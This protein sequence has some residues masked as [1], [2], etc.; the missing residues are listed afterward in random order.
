MKKNMELT[1]DAKYP[2]QKKFFRIMKLTTFLILF[3][4]VCVFASET[5]SQTKKLNLN[6]KKASVK[7]VLSAIEDQSEFKFM[8]SGKI[9]DVNREV[10]INEENSKIEDAL[11]SLFVGTDVEYTIKDRIIVLSASGLLNNEL[12]NSEQQ[13]S[14]SGKVTDN[15]GAGL[16]GVS[17]VVKGTTKGVIT[18]NSGFYS[19][20][21]FS[22]DAALQF[23][24]VGMKMQEIVVGNKTTINVVLEEE[25]IGI[26]EVV[27]VGYGVQRKSD[28]TGAVGSIKAEKLRD[29]PATSVSQAIAGR[30]SGVNVSVNSGRPGGKPNIRVRGNSSISITNEPLYIVDGVISSI[31]YVNPNDIASIEVLKDAS[32]TSIYG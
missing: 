21:G 29:R 15:T 25:M 26:D 8:Y 24:F 19:V 28:L 9:I 22:Q 27:A 30:M 20:I 14:V 3:S 4:V 12:S 17:I 16:P 31:D 2:W 7:V 23:S 5:Y 11:K 10:V 18:D 13:K 1:G 6:M 32:S